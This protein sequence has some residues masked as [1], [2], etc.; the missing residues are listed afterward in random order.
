V[1]LVSEN[2]IVLEVKIFPGSNFAPFKAFWFAFILPDFSGWVF[3]CKS[4]M[5]AI[6]RIQGN[7]T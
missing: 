6:D 1:D 5:I 3:T 4:E 7:L 2:R